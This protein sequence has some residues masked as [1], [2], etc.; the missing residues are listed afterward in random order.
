MKK[1][2][3]QRT[4]FHVEGIDEPC[5][6]VGEDDAQVRISKCYHIIGNN[7]LWVREIL[8][9]EF[10]SEEEFIGDY[11]SLTDDDARRIAKS[12]SVYVY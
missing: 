1:L 10:N 3:V 12:Y 5:I 8:D 6:L 11:D 4:T 9:G 7:T 2:K